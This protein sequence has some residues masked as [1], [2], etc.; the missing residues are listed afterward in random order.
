MKARIS[1]LQPTS[2]VGS[3]VGGP[4]RLAFWTAPKPALMRDKSLQDDRA[5]PH[6]RMQDRPPEP[7]PCGTSHRSLHPHCKE[8][9]FASGGNRRVFLARPLVDCAVVMDALQ[10]WSRAC[11]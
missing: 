2:L 1:P 10:S 11:L 4:T 3:T 7:L 9:H 6:T 5:F 8:G